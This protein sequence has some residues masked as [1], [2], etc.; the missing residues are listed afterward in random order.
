MTVLQSPDFSFT[1]HI[2]DSDHRKRAQ[3]AMALAQ[4]GDHAQ[5]Y[6]DIG[7]LIAE[8]PDNGAVLASIEV[9]DGDAGSVADLVATLQAGGVVLPLIVFAEGAADFLAWP[10]TGEELRSS[11]AYCRQFMDGPGGTLQRRQKARKLVDG[12]S[13][14]ERQILAFLLEGHSNKSMANSLDLSPRTVEDYRLNAMKK[15]GVNA[16]S[17]AIRIGLEAGLDGSGG[18]AS[19]STSFSSVELS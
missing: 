11:C 3:I 18:A 13:I 2:V 17:A 12:L 1:V 6:E 4:C 7:E 16:M 9:A 8:R 19:A 10:F 14:R 15:L 5:I